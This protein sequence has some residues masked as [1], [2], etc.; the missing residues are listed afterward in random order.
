MEQLNQLTISTIR[1]GLKSQLIEWGRR[2]GFNLLSREQTTDFLTPS[3]IGSYP[4]DQITLPVVCDLADPGKHVFDEAVAATEPVY[5]WRYKPAR[6]RALQLSCGTLFSEGN[7]LCPDWRGNRRLLTDV[8][9]LR[10]RPS[11]EVD[12]LIAPWSHY[13][14]G[15]RFGGY[16]D[17]V[18][19]IAAKLCRIKAALP[20][21]VFN[22]SA[23]AYPLFGTT[24]ERE[25]LALIGFGQDQVFDS[26]QTR[27]RFNT[28][29][30]GNSGH[31][32]YPN[33][34]DLL[35]LKRYVEAQLPA[36]PQEPSER[37]ANRVYIS[38][39]VRRRILNEDAL[40]ALLEKYNVRFIEDKP[41][42][43]A[44]QVSIYQNASFIIGPH[45][46]SF[47]NIL[48]CQPGTH[49]VELFSP[50]Y[51]PDF[52]PYMAQRLGL[53]YSGYFQGPESNE[54]FSGL[55]EDI[56]VSI[57]DLDQYLSTLFAAETAA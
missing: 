3:V 1:F 13:L 54:R 33:V 21:E 24:Y 7:V 10:K 23:V 51:V 32:F 38:R 5:V 56:A 11:H 35:A 8:L 25:L 6:K 17:Y 20:E 22:K 50:N 29:V 40:M 41:R 34:A 12:T 16:Y 52:F 30:M 46:A 48:W 2:F 18:I 47:T 43:I 42:T 27:I 44:E 57:P 4:A 26:R 9:T 45:G 39:S 15:I 28:C 14:D 37:M 55:D 31:W 49:L 19:L 53:R 36:H